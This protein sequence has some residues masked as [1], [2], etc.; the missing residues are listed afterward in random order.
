MGAGDRVGTQNM[1]LIAFRVLYFCACLSVLVVCTA[2]YG[3]RAVLRR[4]DQVYI[5]LSLPPVI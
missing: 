2:A 4:L 3:M 1:C 5:A